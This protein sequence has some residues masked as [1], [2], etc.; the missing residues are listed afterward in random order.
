M[1]NLLDCSVGGVPEEGTSGDAS[2]SGSATTDAP[3]AAA[4]LLDEPK[5]LQDS[6]LWDLQRSFYDEKNIKAWSDA[7]VPNFVTT[8]AF[9][10]RAYAKVIL[11]L[12]RDVF[13]TP[14]RGAAGASGAGAGAGASG[15][16]AAGGGSASG[17][18][19][20]AGAS[21]P[22][23]TRPIYIVEIGAGH[24]K[25]GFLV[26]QQLLKLREF[27]PKDHALEF[28]F[29]YVMTDFTEHNVRFW[30]EH[31][32][33]QEFFKMGVLD[34]AV[35]DAESDR[36]LKLEFADEVLAAA[37]GNVT[38]PV[39]AITNYI[40]DTLRTDAFRIVDSELQETCI[41]IHSSD[42]KDVANPA[43]PDVLKRMS[44]KFSYRPVAPETDFYGD[45]D[46]NYIVRSYCERMDEASFLVP[47]GG[48][49]LVR[50]LAS[51]AGGRLL[52]MTGDKGYINESEMAGTRD[53]HIAVHGSF[54]VMVN[55]HALKLYFQRRGGFALHTPHM[56]GFKCANF[57]LGI[58]PEQC[59]H[60][61]WAFK[62]G[63]QEFGPENFSTLQRCIKEECS[64][65]S[66]KH[67]LALL[68]LGGHDSEVFYKFKQALIDK[69]M[70]PYAADNVQKDTRADIDLIE[71]TYY[72]LQASKDV[73]FEIGR[74]LM[75]LKDYRSAISFFERSNEV[76]GQHHVTYHNLGICCYY[77]NDLPSALKCFDASL[78]L[79]GDYA[80]ALSWRAKVDGKMRAATEGDRWNSD[81]EYDSEDSESD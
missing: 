12:M 32:S 11:G 57:Y 46:M 10:A 40:F 9:I 71:E 30:R 70:Y 64:N 23:R 42:A 14:S 54:S 81:E 7:I 4:V 63:I 75:G 72:P 21:V 74:L 24:G 80:D 79:K 51:L 47:I 39:V 61:R 31:A 26:V 73:C 66:L 28:P 45:E 19:G 53:P 33:F 2:G 65:P 56:D 3:Q 78:E 18:G 41:A 43:A 27:F 22:D 77:L 25:L 1:G 35:Y 50:G 44:Y 13:D 60:A 37:H 55:F 38:N 17:S 48:L 49:H 52:L 59:L 58:A 20:G 15:A 16:G 68:R 6:L 5:R 69:T 76:C 36:E 34:V 62:E 67:V 8:N 29:K